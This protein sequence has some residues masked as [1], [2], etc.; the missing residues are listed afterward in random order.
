MMRPSS[1]SSHCKVYDFMEEPTSSYDA[2]ARP[3][4][5]GDALRDVIELKPAG[6]SAKAIQH[7]RHPAHLGRMEQS[8]AQASI[9][10]WCSEVMEM[11]LRFDGDRIADASFWADGCLSTMA[12]GDLLAD[13]VQ[14]MALQDA[15]KIS[16]EELIASLGGLPLKSHHCAEL[17]IDTLRAA[18]ESKR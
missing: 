14:G 5:S 12:C 9:V 2:T 10:G 11:Y 17:A 8:D 6:F 13:T 18:L 7:A 16:P 1:S 3:E 4:A 15:V